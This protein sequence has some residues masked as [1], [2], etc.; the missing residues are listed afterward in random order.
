MY[1]YFLL[2]II[3]EFL[4]IN[5]DIKAVKRSSNSFYAITFYCCHKFLCNTATF[6]YRIFVLLDLESAFVIVMCPY[7]VRMILLL[8]LYSVCLTKVDADPDQE[9]YLKNAILNVE[10]Y[11]RRAHQNKE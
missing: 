7:V 10:F 8:H 3:S 6:N 11:L 4:R 9:A 5:Q 2:I 1:S